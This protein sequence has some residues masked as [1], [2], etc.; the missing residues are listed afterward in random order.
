M[1]CKSYEVYKYFLIDIFF[2]DYINLMSESK[3]QRAILAFVGEMDGSKLQKFNSLLD[4]HNTNAFFY[5][6]YIK[7]PM[8]NEPEHTSYHMTWDQVKEP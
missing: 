2:E 4:S 1:Y 7:T 3:V 5:M 6:A 8:S